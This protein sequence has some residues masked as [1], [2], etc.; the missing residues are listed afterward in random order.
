MEKRGIAFL[1]MSVMIFSLVPSYA[2]AAAADQCT[3]ID[4]NTGECL[5][6]PSGEMKDAVASPPTVARPNIAYTQQQGQSQSSGFLGGLFD[7]I[8]TPIK[9]VFD[10]I[11]SGFS[12]K[13]QAAT[14]EI[15]APG[16]EQGLGQ[17]APTRVKTT[18][19]AT[20]Q[21]S[22]SYFEFIR[23]H[24][25]ITV[26]SIAAGLFVSPF[27]FATPI[28]YKWFSDRYSKKA[29]AAGIAAIAQQQPAPV[30]NTEEWTLIFNFDD[31][32]WSAFSKIMSP[33]KSSTVKVTVRCEK[34]ETMDYLYESSKPYNELTCKPESMVDILGVKCQ[35]PITF[36]LSTSSEGAEITN[37]RQLSSA[38][39]AGVCSSPE[40][41]NWGCR[42]YRNWFSYAKGKVSYVDYFNTEERQLVKDPYSMTGGQVQFDLSFV[43]RATGQSRTIQPVASWTAIR[44]TSGSSASSQQAANAKPN[45]ETQTPQWIQ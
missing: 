10:F 39:Y 3:F 2:L 20:P 19:Q 26:A 4:I 28:A 22:T 33:P 41:V 11:A 23:T 37:C 45:T 31:N 14:T 15:S 29:P 40:L 21:K 13:P 36:D 43:N 1:L 27:F 7:F 30:Q 5:S 38:K 9:K 32:Y 17:A 35:V 34:K 16:E 12:E 8:F 25:L 24:K 44:W 18:Q 6:A 42:T